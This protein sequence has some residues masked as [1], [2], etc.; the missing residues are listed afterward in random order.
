[1]K[2][3]KL[4][5]QMSSLLLTLILV[6]CSTTKTEDSTTAGDNNS[7][8]VSFNKIEQEYLN[9]LNNLHWPEGTILP[10]TLEGETADSFQIGYGDSRA[11]M[12]WE[13]TWQKEWLETYN[14]NPARANLALEELEKAFNMGY[15]S[16][17]RA[18]DST[19]NYFKEIL[20]KAKLGD[21]S[22]FEESIRANSIN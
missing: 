1:M 9:S 19:R 15:M 22:G 2:Y 3:L 8:F 4:V 14:T 5:A 6:G 18:D 7:S 10:T 20:E 16:P 12:L 13:I 17:Q 11:S 21:P